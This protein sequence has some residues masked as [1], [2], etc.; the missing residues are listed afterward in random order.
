MTRPSMFVILL[1]RISD[2][3]RE[4]VHQ[5]I[6]TNADTWW[7]RF[8]NVWLAEGRSVHDWRDLVY[9]VLVRPGSSSVLVLKLPED[10]RWW[11]LHGTNVREKARWLYETYSGKTAPWITEE[12]TKHISS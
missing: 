8:E 10:E 9:E 1:D 3:E 12:A 6:K 5:V 11:S 7:H 4:A 2:L